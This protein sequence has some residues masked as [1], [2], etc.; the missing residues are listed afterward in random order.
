MGYCIEAVPLEGLPS[1]VVR[2]IL[3]FVCL[4]R[5]FL[6]RYVTRRN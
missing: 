6:R 4:C 1:R 3:L 2:A 5:Y